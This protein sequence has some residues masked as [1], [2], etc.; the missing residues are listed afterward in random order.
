MKL[1]IF[2][3]DGVLIDSREIHF[4]AL[5]NALEE[6]DKKYI[7]TEEEQNTKFDGLPT[8]KK[9]E[10]LTSLKGLSPNEYTKIWK[11]KQQL[12][13]DILD[14]TITID[15]KLIEIME[16]LVDK[17]YKICV[18]SNSIKH[19]IMKILEKKGIKKYIDLVVSNEDVAYPKPNPQMHLNFCSPISFCS[20][21]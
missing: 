4:N 14:T 2:D 11:R 1:V 21:C 7:I 13:F 10:L 6:V 15:N 3:L 9:L 8:N 17:E 5:N 19:T 18:A 12:T 16:Y 20:P